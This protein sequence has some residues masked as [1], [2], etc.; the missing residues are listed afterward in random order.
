M[1]FGYLGDTSTKIKQVKKNQGVLSISD[2]YE[3]EKLGHIGG[4]LELLQTISISSS[5]ATADFTNIKED[6]YDVHLLTV[7]AEGGSDYDILLS[8]DNGSSFETSNYE[9][10]LQYGTSAG[11]F[12][13][14]KS[15]STNK[16]MVSQGSA[17]EAAVV[18][19]YKLGDS[20]KYS[21]MNSHAQGINGLKVGGNCYKV[22]ETIN[23]IRFDGRNGDITKA[24][25]KLYGI[26]NL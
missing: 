9:N 16:M 15:T 12:G 22:A 5:T 6:V 11:S 18:Y 2:V 25:L 14:D 19:F 17:N 13:E 21:F 4:S 24:G 7:F 10:G 26:K 3:L 1:S 8:N 23:A 20:S